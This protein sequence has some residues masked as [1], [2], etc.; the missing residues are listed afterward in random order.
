MAAQLRELRAV[1]FCDIGCQAVR[2]GDDLKRRY[3]SRDVFADVGDQVPRGGT[4]TKHVPIDWDYLHEHHLECWSALAH[5]RT[6][7]TSL[8]RGLS[9]KLGLS[10][11]LRS[12][13]SA[14]SSARRCIHSAAQCMHP[15]H[16]LHQ[17]D[18][19]P[20]LV[21]LWRPL[22]AHRH[23]ATYRWKRHDTAAASQVHGPEAC[24]VGFFCL[25]HGALSN[26]T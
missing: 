5:P 20:G 1:E 2:L 6:L 8:H 14:M 22:H 15:E 4:A 3:P 21:K 25:W 12:D 18:E 26:C 16:A 13:E 7:P 17:G 19:G 10:S 23:E 9:W 11:P 24:M